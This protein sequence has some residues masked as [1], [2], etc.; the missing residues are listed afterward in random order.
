MQKGADRVRRTRV[1]RRVER[2]QNSTHLTFVKMAE[3]DVVVGLMSGT[4]L[5]GVD[6]AAV[7]TDGHVVDKFVATASLSYSAEVRK[8]LQAATQE[9]LA[10]PTAVLRDASAW[11]TIL[12]RAAEVV[13]EQH[14]TAVEMLPEAVLKRTCLIG[15]HGQTVVHRPAEAF[16]LQLGDGKALAARLKRTVAWDFRS[17]D[18]Y[19]GG[20]GAPLAPFYHFALAASLREPQCPVAFLN[21]GGVGNVTWVDVTK[22]GP[23]ADGALVAFDTGP[24]N[25]LIDL[26]VEACTGGKST[27]DKD[28]AYA[29]AGRINEAELKSLLAATDYLKKPSPKSLDRH[30]FRVPDQWQLSLEDGCRTLTALT[31]ECVALAAQHLP[32]PP[33]IWFVCGGGRLNSCLMDELKVR[34]SG[35]VV[36]VEEVGFDG[37]ALEA[38]AFAFLAARTQRQL[39]LSSPA[40]TGC[41]K[42]CCGG[43]LSDP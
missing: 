26:W 3:G 20:Q 30:D 4:S 41:P 29:A 39:P 43:R 7:V 37:D 32:Q 27:F 33:Q 16:T 21:L 31:A 23:E 1:R 8:L 12:L 2:R 18:V 25:G 42:P 10:T 40:T 13:V 15:F 5:D 14:A 9:A 19:Q 17:N 6:V 24:G 22:P 38:Q 28:G 11:P 34:L 36:A 35:Q